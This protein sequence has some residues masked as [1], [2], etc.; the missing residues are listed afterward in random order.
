[1]YSVL[2]FHNVAK[3]TEFYMGQFRFKKSF[4][5]VA[6]WLRKYLYF[7]AYKLSIVNNTDKVVRKEFCMQM[8]NWIQYDERFLISVIF[9][10]ER[11]FHVSGKV[12]THNCRTWGSENPRVSLEH[13]HDSPKVNVFCALSKTAK[14]FITF[15]KCANTSTPVSQVEGWVEWRR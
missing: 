3:H 14:P 13:V 8:L 5:T 10:D 4:T 1:M 12:K 7:E 2:N 6:V 9:S 15:D 11:T